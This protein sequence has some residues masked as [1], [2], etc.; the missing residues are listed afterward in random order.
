M[1]PF[2][3][4]I[5]GV[6]PTPAKIVILGE[7]PGE[8]EAKLGIP[9][10]GYSG[11]ELDKL[12]AQVGINRGECYLTSV[13][14]SR[15]QDNKFDEH[16]LVGKKVLPPGYNLPPVSLGK[17]LHP[18]LLPEIVRLDAELKAARPNLIIALGAKALW[19]L[20]GS[21][22]ISS[23]RGTV[24]A[25]PYG[26]AL[27]TYHPAYTLRDWSAR[28]I[29][30]GD[31]IKAE[32]E[33]HFPEIRRPERWILIDPSVDEVEAAVERT[34]LLPG[35]SLDV[36]TRFRTIT[37]LGWS[38]SRSEAIVVPFYHPTRGSYFTF[39]DERKVRHLINRI[40]SAPL[41][42]TCQNGMYDIQYLLKEGFKL[43]NFLEDT[44]LMHHALYPELPK[45]LGFLGAAY[46]SESAW[47]RMRNQ[48]KAKDT[49]KED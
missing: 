29:L 20:V 5:R 40:T 43:C 23:F 16:F 28:P 39:D 37:V 7:A 33:S 32:R 19:A 21:S 42:K 22:A 41:I 25:T 1:S 45:S 38:L 14:H 15:P 17:Y 48:A 18:D 30:L 44:M 31:L 35:I 11:Q 47:K 46:T 8:T 9:F 6:G 2:S 13:C 27:P 12:L 24:L 4:C 26:K 34:L 36:E 3:P 10:V 49:K